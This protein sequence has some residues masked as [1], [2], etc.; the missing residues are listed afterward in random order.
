M[1]VLTFVHFFYSVTYVQLVISLGDWTWCHFHGWGMNDLPRRQIKKS[2]CEKIGISLSHFVFHLSNGCGRIFFSYCETKVQFM[3]TLCGIELFSLGYCF[4]GRYPSG[5]HWKGFLILHQ[6]PEKARI[7]RYLQEI[8][9]AERRLLYGRVTTH[10][11]LSIGGVIQGW[12][13]RF[14]NKYSTHYIA[15]LAHFYLL[16]ID[17]KCHQKV[18]YLTLEFITSIMLIFHRRFAQ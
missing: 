7:S 2:F 13:C 18:D 12:C 16:S 14:V 17:C 6:N 10:A 5:G 9:W 3:I 1:A 8:K 11:L 4:R 15:Q